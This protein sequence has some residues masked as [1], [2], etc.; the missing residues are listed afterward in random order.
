MTPERIQR[1]QSKMGM[2]GSQMANCLGVPYRTYANWYYGTRS[3]PSVYAYVF[4]SWER[5]IEQKRTDELLS[6]IQ[7]LSFMAFLGWLLY[8]IGKE[9][10]VTKN[11]TK[12]KRRKDAD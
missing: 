12:P 2:T 9:T 8:E 3:V 4:E 5:L 1:I 11:P 10:A 6:K 7:S